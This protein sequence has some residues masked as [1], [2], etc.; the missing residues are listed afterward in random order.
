MDFNYLFIYLFFFLVMLPSESPRLTIDPPMRVFPGVW[1]LLSFQ[2]SLAGMDLHPY[3]FC[4]SFYLSYFV[5]PPLRQW[6]AFLG[7]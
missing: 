7:A 6:A 5:L 1:K 2:D 4:L 3:L